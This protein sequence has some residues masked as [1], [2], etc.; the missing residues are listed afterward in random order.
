MYSFIRPA[1]RTSSFKIVP[2]SFFSLYTGNTYYMYKIPHTCCLYCCVVGVK[3]YGIRY[4][5]ICIYEGASE[6]NSVNEG[7]LELS[8]LLFRRSSEGSKGRK[9]GR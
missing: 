6:R 1:V 9:A 4:V 8:V 7:A 3:Y 2:S 5:F